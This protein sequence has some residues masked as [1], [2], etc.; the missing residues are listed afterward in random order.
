MEK[1]SSPQYVITSERINQL[2]K[3]YGPFDSIQ[4]AKDWV[5]KQEGNNSIVTFDNQINN[6]AIYCYNL[7]TLCYTILRLKEK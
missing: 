3:A 7:L 2:K 1:S 5:L 4:E 6:D